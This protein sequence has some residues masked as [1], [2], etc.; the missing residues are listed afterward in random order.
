M[1][2]APYPDDMGTAADRDRV[3]QH[4]LVVDDDP[5]SRSTL[6][7]A[8][9]RHGFTV[10]A[11]ATAREALAIEPLPP[12]AL[13]DLH[14][15]H[16]PTGIDLAIALRERRP[17][18]GLV[19]LTTYDDPRLLSG[20]LPPTPIGTRY[21]RKRDVTD[22]RVVI[23]TLA[24]TRS[25][26]LNAARDSRIELTSTMLDV[27]RMVAE[28]LSTQEIARRRDVSPKAVESIITKLCEYFGLGRESSHNQRVRLVAEYFALTGQVPR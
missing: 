3:A 22:I 24:A 4:V 28:G 8:L 1:T 15:G 20:A 6:A 27:L 25:A 2:E 10:T 9:E 19:L 11:L 17:T 16:G 26:P 23:A 18:I 21:L 12:L 5:F 7:P 14:L 13:L